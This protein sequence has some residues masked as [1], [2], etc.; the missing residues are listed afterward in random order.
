[1]TR[2]PLHSIAN[3]NSYSSIP[4]PPFLRESFLVI[5]ATLD[6]ILLSSYFKCE[7]GKREERND[8]EE[9]VE[10]RNFLHKSWNCNLYHRF[11]LKSSQSCN[12]IVF[13]IAYKLSCCRWCRWKTAF[14]S[15]WI[16][17]ISRSLTLDSL[18]FLTLDPFQEMRLFSSPFIPI[19]MIIKSFMKWR[20][21]SWQ[22]AANDIH[23]FSPQSLIAFNST[24]SLAS[25]RILLVSFNF[26]QLSL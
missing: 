13:L 16:C 4:F 26:F 14:C 18:S 9:Q 5:I 17:S 8:D 12:F 20:K 11:G 22:C 23:L 6:F 21:L 25:R 3:L 19:L 15:L 7:R 10:E 2:K 1:M 24:F